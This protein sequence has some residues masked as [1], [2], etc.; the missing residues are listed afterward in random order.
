MLV[1]G[2]AGFIGSNFVRYLLRR[3]DKFKVLNIDK[4]T[5]SGNLLNLKSIENNSRYSFV[6]GDITNNRL[7]NEIFGEYKVDTILNFAAESHVDRSI[8]NPGSFLKTNI[9]GTHVLLEAARKHGVDRFIQV[10]T[11][12][13]Y[14]SVSSGKSME[15]DALMPNSPYSASKAS[16]DLL[17]RA[18]FK[19]FGVPVIITRSSNN[20]GPYQYPE[21]LIPLMIINIIEEKPLP[22]YADGKNERDWIYV[23]DNCRAIYEVL[24]KGKSGEIYN[25]GSGSTERNID[26]VKKICEIMS[27]KTGRPVDDVL[28]LIT[29]VKDR[30]G[31][32]FRYC[33]D[34]SRIQNETDWKP[35]TGIEEGLKKTVDWYLSNKEW[36]NSVRDRSYTKY[37]RQN[38][39]NR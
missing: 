7:I 28:S 21:K 24:Q 31:H 25:I 38:Y 13:V 10:S 22:V 33:M 26:I 19:T 17:C 3:N 1:T 39:Q 9:T 29:Y 11:D 36:I 37:Y 5:Y 27:K 30:P 15:K 35:S 34:N 20:Y 16:A 4:L 14:G 6:K 18:Y 12:E 32:D 2:G 8:I 23:E